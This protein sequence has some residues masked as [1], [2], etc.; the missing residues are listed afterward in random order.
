VKRPSVRTGT[1]TVFGV[2]PSAAEHASSSWRKWD[3]LKE[4][5]RRAEVEARG[6]AEVADLY[7]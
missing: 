1:R 6:R 4:A 5:K 3:H 7:E 2:R